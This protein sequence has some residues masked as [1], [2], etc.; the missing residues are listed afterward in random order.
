MNRVFDTVRLSSKLNSSVYSTPTKQSSTLLNPQLSVEG[1]FSPYFG[2]TRNMSSGL[3][4]LDSG[5]DSDASFQTD[6]EDN[7]P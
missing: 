2:G 1:R 7:Y 5:A 6:S 3:P 4:S